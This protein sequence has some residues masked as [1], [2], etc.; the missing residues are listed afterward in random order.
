MVSSL[1]DSFGGYLVTRHW[2][3]KA[4]S[5]P[6]GALPP[7]PGTALAEVRKIVIGDTGRRGLTAVDA[8]K[9]LGQAYGHF[10]VDD[11]V[12]IECV[13]A[14]TSSV[15]F[16]EQACFVQLKPGFNAQECA[17]TVNLCFG[18]QITAK[19][20]YGR[21][22][23][24]AAFVCD[25]FNLDPTKDVKRA[26]DIDIARKDPDQALQAA[27]TDFQ[28]LLNEIATKLSDAKAPAVQPPG[29]ADVPGRELAH[30]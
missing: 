20:M 7:R 19:D 12:I 9:D 21:C 13:P 11:T 29:P 30:A 23:A 10:I 28:K 15:G 2:I 24:L 5:K 8:A 27:G 18:G 3:P 22:V 6:K 17:I 25:R 1:P 26:G 4:Q 14:L 16:V